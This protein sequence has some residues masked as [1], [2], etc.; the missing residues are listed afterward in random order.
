MEP[1]Q[2]TN[3]NIGEEVSEDPVDNQLA[4]EDILEEIILDDN[5]NILPDDLDDSDYNPEDDDPEAS[6][7]D[8]IV[9]GEEG[10]IEAEGDQ[11]ALDAIESKLEIPAS[12]LT[13]AG[14]IR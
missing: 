5:D 14:T 1:E 7:D 13:H 3:S 4:P 10:D 6:D 12:K 11:Q 8:I 9:E 2:P